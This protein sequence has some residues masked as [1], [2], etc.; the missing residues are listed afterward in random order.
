M[1]KSNSVER[2]QHVF[3]ILFLVYIIALLLKFLFSI[4][5]VTFDT[6]SASLCVYILFGVLWA[7]VFSLVD[8][9]GESA[10]FANNLTPSHGDQLIHFEGSDTTTALYYSF[11]TM[12]T[13]GY[14]D[15]TP[16]SPMARILSAI[17]AMIGQMYLAVLVARLVGLHIAQKPRARRL[18]NHESTSGATGASSRCQPVT[19]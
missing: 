3:S 13:L 18:N 19:T 8:L 1:S 14:G 4:D 10:A 15:I 12:T 2:L 17:E 16:V 5:R 9:F 7:I 6:I 11:V